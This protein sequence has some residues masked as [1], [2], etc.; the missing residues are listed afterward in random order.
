[1]S[2]EFLDQLEE[3]LRDENVP[4]ETINKIAVALALDAGRRVDRFEQQ[5]DG[6]MDELR[7]LIQL[8]TENIARLTADVQAQKAYMAQHPSLLYLLR[9]RTKETVATILFIILV[10]SMWYVS[11]IRQPLLKWF[12]L[13]VF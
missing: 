8:Q 13:P 6:Y 1:M 2:E 7:A 11:G 5:M 9:F 3:I 4:Q 12:G 10:L